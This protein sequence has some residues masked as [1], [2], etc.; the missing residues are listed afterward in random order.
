MRS[1]IEPMKR[2]AKTLRKHRPLLMVWFKTKGALSSGVVEGT[3]NKAILTMRKP[4]GF[5]T[6]KG[7][8]TALYHAMGNFLTTQE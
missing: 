7:I 1:K 8:E 4:Y 5:R 3:N 6:F 2:M